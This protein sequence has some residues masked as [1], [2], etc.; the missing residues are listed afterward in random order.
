MSVAQALLL[1]LDTIS[2]PG[3]DGSA[4]AATEESEASQ[5]PSAR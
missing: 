1:L 2:P 4:A 5:V 3:A